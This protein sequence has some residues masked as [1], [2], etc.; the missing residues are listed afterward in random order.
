VG[1]ELASG[2]NSWSALSDRNIKENVTPLDRRDV[3]ERLHGVPVTMWNLKSQVP[4]ILH[5]GPMAQDFHAAFG[6]GERETHISSSDADGV[7]LAAIQGLYE[8][9]MEKDCEIEELR[10]EIEKLKEAMD[11]R[12]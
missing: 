5:I 7:A 6:L 1:V 8:I 2:G 12:P 11:R 4:S 9:V 10:S 3:L